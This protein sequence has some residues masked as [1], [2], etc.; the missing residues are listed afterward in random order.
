ML[1]NGTIDTLIY[2]VDIKLTDIVS[3]DRDDVREIKSLK[4][5]VDELKALQSGA[6]RT[7]RNIAGL[8]PKSVRCGQHISRRTAIIAL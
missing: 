6:N 2:L 5:C 4:A 8:Q 3:F 1:S 7:S